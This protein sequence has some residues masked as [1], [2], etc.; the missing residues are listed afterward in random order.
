M[1]KQAGSIVLIFGGVALIYLA[2]TGYLESAWMGLRGQCSGGGSQ[3]PEGSN[4]SS[5]GVQQGGDALGRRSLGRGQ[6]GQVSNVP[7]V[8]KGGYYPGPSGALMASDAGV[9]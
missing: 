5:T 4:A 3:I 8:D 1:G 6:G 9:W 2:A 7:Y